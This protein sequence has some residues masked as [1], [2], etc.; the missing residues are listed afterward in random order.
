MILTPEQVAYAKMV[1]RDVQIEVLADSHEELRAERD[2]AL[3]RVAELELA[4]VFED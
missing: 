1:S 2:A 4:I 3:E